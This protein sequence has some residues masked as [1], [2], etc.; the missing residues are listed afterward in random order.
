VIFFGGIASYTSIFI[1]T[2]YDFGR[3]GGSPP[4]A[5]LNVNLILSNSN[6][7]VYSFMANCGVPREGTKS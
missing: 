2:F 3:V 6:C 7:I 4:K 5:I 1:L